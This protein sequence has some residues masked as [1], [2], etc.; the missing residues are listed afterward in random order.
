MADKYEYIPETPEFARFWAAYPKKQNKA[1]AKKAWA[2]TAMIR[3]QIEV[4]L[5]AVIA[6]KS[7]ADWRK[8]EGRYIPLPSSWLRAEGWE[9]SADVDLGDVVDGRMWHET[10]AGIIRKGAELGLNW[11]DEKWE[12]MSKEHNGGIHPWRFFKRDVFKA[13]G[14]N[15]TQIKAA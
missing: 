3:P 12:R 1:D 15:V 4:V 8:E 5:K 6:Q 2:Q 13:A 10:D 7:C 14:H 11:P 9:N